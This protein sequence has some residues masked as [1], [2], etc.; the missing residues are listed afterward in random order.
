MDLNATWIRLRM[1]SKTIAVVWDE[2]FV[3]Y[4]IQTFFERKKERKKERKTICKA[5]EIWSH[6][7]MDYLSHMDYFIIFFVY[8]LYPFWSLNT[9]VPIHC[10][11]TENIIH[12]SIFIV[13][14]ST[15]ESKLIRFRT[16]GGLHPKKYTQKH[17]AQW[18]YIFTHIWM[19]PWI[20]IYSNCA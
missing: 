12:Q 5:P 16:A 15:K 17:L 18:L 6:G 1:L 4:T 20:T 3:K 10:N 7:H 14:C 2:D 13:V 9:P 8:I 11:C 19:A